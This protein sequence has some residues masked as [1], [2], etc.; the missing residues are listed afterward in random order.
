VKE[1]E[2]YEFRV[3]SNGITS[4]SNFMKI[5]PGIL[6]LLSTNML[7]SFARFGCD[8]HAQRITGNS[9]IIVPPHEFEHP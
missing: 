1:I 3:I 4:I 2:K 5:R 7:I 6:Y 8:A 9:V